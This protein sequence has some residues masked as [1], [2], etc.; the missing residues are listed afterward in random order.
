MLAPEKIEHNE[1][2]LVPPLFERDHKG[3]SRLA[4]SSY[5]FLFCKPNLRWLYN[6]YLPCGMKSLLHFSPPE[7][8]R[9]SLT[10]RLTASTRVGD[11]LRHVEL[12]NNHFGA[13]CTQLLTSTSQG[14]QCEKENVVLR[15]ACFQQMHHG[16]N[17]DIVLTGSANV[18]FQTTPM[19]P[20]N[21]V[22]LKVSTQVESFAEP[23]FLQLAKLPP[24]IFLMS[25]TRW[26]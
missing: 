13:G 17:V 4:K 15:F 21:F 12:G 25:K 18:R 14:H 9:I 19:N 2:V 11:D 5:D 7:D 6:D 24:P 3:R 10:A 23:N 16:A 22:D 1:V 26:H 20:S 8:P